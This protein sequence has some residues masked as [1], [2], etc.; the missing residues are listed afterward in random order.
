[1]QQKGQVGEFGIVWPD[2]PKAKL[3]LR[4]EFIGLSNAPQMSISAPFEIGFDW[5]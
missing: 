1:M 2:S 4:K 3:V 5:V